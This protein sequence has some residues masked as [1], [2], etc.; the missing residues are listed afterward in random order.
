[1]ETN[2]KGATGPM[3]YQSKPSP[4]VS[5]S[6]NNAA[7]D[8]RLMQY[9]TELLPEGMD[10][11][12]FKRLLKY[13]YDDTRWMWRDEDQIWHLVLNGVEVASSYHIMCYDNMRYSWE[14]RSRQ[15]HLIHGAREM[16]VADSVRSYSMKRYAY[17][18]D[19]MWNLIHDGKLVASGIDVQS[20]APDR[21]YWMDENGQCHFHGC[22][23]R[24]DP[25]EMINPPN[26][27]E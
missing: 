7:K 9:D 16:V 6:V 25:R 15:V 1:M 26:A 4:P 24:P 2:P 3:F 19:G 18:R 8:K 5:M 23:G 20:Y 22:G 11:N 10:F 21:W 17:Y 13:Y 12:R 27:I 14:D